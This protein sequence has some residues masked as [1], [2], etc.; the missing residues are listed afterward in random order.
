MADDQPL[1]PAVIQELNKAVATQAWRLAKKQAAAPA[2]V[3]GNS[4]HAHPDP[5]RFASGYRKP[6]RVGDRMTCV[7]TGRE[8]VWDGRAWAPA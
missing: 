5:K 6:P 7:V 8:S 2:F 1:H 4:A 3:M